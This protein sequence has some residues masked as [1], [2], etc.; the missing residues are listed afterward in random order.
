MEMKSKSQTGAHSR[1]WAELK[2]THT[3]S[4]WPAQMMMTPRYAYHTV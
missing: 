4:C 3:G 1:A 2:A